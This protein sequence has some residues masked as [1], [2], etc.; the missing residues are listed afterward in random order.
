LR[1]GKPQRG[2]RREHRGQV[3]ALGLDE[4][5]DEYR[6]RAPCRR[7]P[8]I[9]VDPSAEEL[10]VVT[11]NQERA[12]H[13]EREESGAD[14]RHADESERGGRQEAAG[15]ERDEPSIWNGGVQ[16]VAVQLIER[17]GRNT[18][19]KEKGEER[20]DE[21]R[22][23]GSWREARADDHVGQV[24]GRIRGVQQ[25]PPV[26]PPARPRRVEGRPFHFQRL[27][28]SAHITSPPP[29]LIERT[30]MFTSPASFHAPTVQATE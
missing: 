15:T 14:D 6:K 27:G 26:A 10:E 1:E 4:V 16:R 24:P 3:Q 8:E 30:P 17:M 19:G 11:Q 25:R 5:A 13:D 20:R 28:F 7:E 9:G 21:M 29:R 12:D 23:V 2:E 18:D 22:A